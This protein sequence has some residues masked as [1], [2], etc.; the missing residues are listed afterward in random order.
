MPLRKR[1]LNEI[2][3]EKIASHLKLYIV[4]LICELY[5]PKW[6]SVSGIRRLE[7]TCRFAK[8]YKR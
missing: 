3:V 4:A 7:W 5:Y 2:D 6:Y 1:H 8:V